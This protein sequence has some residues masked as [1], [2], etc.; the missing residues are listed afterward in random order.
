MPSAAP[1]PLATETLRVAGMPNRDRLLAVLVAILWGVNFLAFHFLLSQFPP[2]LAASLRF[3]VLAVP[4][5]LFVPWPKVRPL[6]LLGVGLGFGTGQFAFL[7]IALGVG[8]PTGLASLVLQAQ[9]PFTVLLGT[10][11]L[12]ERLSAG[13]L[14]GIA[15]AVAGMA[16]IAW[17]RAENAALLP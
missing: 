4:T 17:H 3:L 9:A 2:L 12:R 13:Q 10:V 5:I 8:M 15:L 16:V 7:F 1:P 14:A 11:F 6:W